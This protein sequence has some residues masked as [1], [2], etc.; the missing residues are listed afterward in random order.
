MKSAYKMVE[1]HIAGTTMMSALAK[2]KEANSKGLLVSMSFL[3]EPPSD[4]IKSRYITNTYMQLARQ[5][6]RLSINGNVHVPVWQLGISLDE[7]MAVGN[8]RRIMDTCA[9]YGIFQWYEVNDEHDISAVRKAGSKGYGIAFGSIELAMKYMRARKM[10][11]AKLVFTGFSGEDIRLDEKEVEKTIKAAIESCEK[12]TLSSVPDNVLYKFIRKG[13]ARRTTI[14]EMQYGYERMISEAY[15][16][17]YDV[18]VLMP[19][20]KDWIRYALS[21]IPS[22][23][24]HS[25]AS[26]LLEPGADL[27][28]L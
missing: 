5:L 16:S 25:L 6:S 24:L 8:L 27:E 13:K 20:G 4:M 22:G 2:A 1:K 9:T 7:G 17:G 18:S 19:F 15:K 11:D 28:I 12:L 26:S 3:S 21:K 10:A 23:K 14:I